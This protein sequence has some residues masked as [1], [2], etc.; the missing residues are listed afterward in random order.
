[1]I[2]W[3]GVGVSMTPTLDTSTLSPLNRAR[4]AEGC[5]ANVIDA[6]HTDRYRSCARSS[7]TNIDIR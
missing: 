2:I 3:I 7:M 4:K 6:S 5:E 1:M